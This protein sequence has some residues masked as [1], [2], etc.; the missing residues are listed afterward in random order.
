MAAT[1]PRHRLWVL[2]TCTS[3]RTLKHPATQLRLHYGRRWK[4]AAQATV[5]YCRI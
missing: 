2:E 5:S 3:L 1:Y 4:Q